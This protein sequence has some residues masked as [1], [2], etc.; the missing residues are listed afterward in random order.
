METNNSHLQSNVPNDSEDFGNV[1]NVA[2]A[3]RIIPNSSERTENH[4]L[5]VREVARRFEVAGVARTERSIINWCQSNKLGVSRL[6]A[7]F[8]PNERKYFMTTESVERAIAE[9]KAKATKTIESAEIF[10]T[11]PNDAER[12]SEQ[13]PPSAEPDSDRA[14]EMEKELMDLKITNRAKDHFIE[15]MKGERESF[16]AERQEYVAK[17]MTFNRKVGELET[18]LLQIDSPKNSIPEG[19]EEVGLLH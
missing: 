7:Y 17:L 9:E 5:T 4:T 15:L 14:R 3:F 16:A 19:V 12:A 11:I 1:P 13:R 10:G 6:D 18:K 2:E 8:D